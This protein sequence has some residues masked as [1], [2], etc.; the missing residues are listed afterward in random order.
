MKILFVGPYRQG[1]GWG[2]AARGH[3]KALM[4]TSHELA[5]RPIYMAPN[6]TEVPPEFAQLEKNRCEKFDLIIQ[7]VLP[8]Y[9]ERYGD[10]KCVGLSMLETG[11]LQHTTWPYHMNLMDEIWVSSQQELK[12]I[13]P[14]ITPSAVVHQVP[15][16][17]SKFNYNYDTSH[18]QRF[19]FHDKFVFY[20]VGENIPRKN[21]QAL[22]MAFHLEFD[23]SEQVEL[24]IKT[25]KAGMD[26][27]QLYRAIDDKSS[28][29]KKDMQLYADL[30][31]YKSECVVTETLTPEHLYGLHQIC[32]CFVMP[33]RGE[34]CCQPMLDA[35][36]FGNPVIVTDNTGMTT[37]M[38][39]TVG[40][41]VDSHRTPVLSKEKP[42]PFLYT[43][44]ETWSEIDILK[45]QQAM[46]CAY[47]QDTLSKAQMSSRCKEHV[48]Q[49]SYENMGAKLQEML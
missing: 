10:S 1:D 3:I 15:I 20:F 43:S 35:L 40:W 14:L 28:Q 48:Q 25:N 39:E 47:K 46:R 12:D 26:S 9:L 23:L 5:I 21:L 31:M 41:K 49:F 17:V 37:Y 44:R 24:L 19:G 45:L 42:M 4:H 38:D 16:D 34:A 2:E 7:N 33:S 29:I 11:C 32:D 27:S 22:I 18:W 36:G 6:P 30:S 8:T 13:T